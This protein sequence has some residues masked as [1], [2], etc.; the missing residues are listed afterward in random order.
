M[1]V[2]AGNKAAVVSAP[3]SKPKVILILMVAG[4]PDDDKR[5]LREISRAARVDEWMCG[6]EE[7][8][9]PSHPSFH[10]QRV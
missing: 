4:A 7:G 9:L 3:A 6:G 2:T 10:T 1:G 5:E 8:T